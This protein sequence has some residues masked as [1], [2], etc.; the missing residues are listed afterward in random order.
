MQK[1]EKYR[2]CG[3]TFFVLLSDARKPLLSK[4]ENYKGKKS[5]ITETELLLSLARIVI[6]DIPEPMSSELKSLRDSTNDFKSCKNWG[7]GF[8][9]LGDKSVKKSFDERLKNNYS[10]SL[11]AM[12]KLV[13]K[14]IDAETS[15]KKDEYL[16]KA[17]VE[18]IMEDDKILPEQLLYI[19]ANGQPIEK[20]MLSSISEI[21]LQSF[22]LG[23]WH[24]AVTGIK[25]NSIG[26]KTYEECC[27][28]HNGS[29]GSK[30]EYVAAIGENSSLN[31]HLSYYENDHLCD[32]PSDDVDETENIDEL[33]E[34]EI[35]DDIKNDDTAAQHIDNSVMVNIGNGLQIKENHGTLN[36][37]LG[38]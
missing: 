28:P 33:I 38:K 31:I 18:V 37:V 14:Y 8:F 22:L 25:E 5:G 30:R 3:G 17:L 36:I 1:E 15:T 4:A 32:E 35:V 20:K 21:C 13:D 29:K 7:G 24:F 9:R 34:T 19:Q 26:R 16:V 23:I 10:E 12:S 11:T 2:L 27:P 6:P